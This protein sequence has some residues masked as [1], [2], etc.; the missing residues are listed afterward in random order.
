[1]GYFFELI[2]DQPAAPVKSSMSTTGWSTDPEPTIERQSVAMESP[3]VI[4]VATS[5]KK[6]G[7]KKITKVIDFEQ[8]AK[9]AE[10]EAVRVESEKA[11]VV[12]ARLK[13]GEKTTSSGGFQMSTSAVP[14]PFV[15][16]PS[17]ASYNEPA[18]VEFKK[19]L[20]KCDLP[21]L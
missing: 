6:R 11:R 17:V 13:R 19:Y 4:P 20:R 18:V 15:K 9:D 3:A 21:I 5:Y 14:A 10:A 16:T 1:M 2:S 8:A 7:A 12:E